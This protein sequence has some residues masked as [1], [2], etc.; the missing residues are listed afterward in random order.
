MKTFCLLFGL[1]LVTTILFGQNKNGA[2][3][4]NNWTWSK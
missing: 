4:N 2:A 3:I 1:I